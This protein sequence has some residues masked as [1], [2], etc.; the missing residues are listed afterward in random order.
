MEDSSAVIGMLVLGAWS[1]RTLREFVLAAHDAPFRFYVH[2]DRKVD[3][4]AYLADLGPAVSRMRLVPDRQ[5]VFWGGWS[6]VRATMV[7]MEAALADSDIDILT[8]VSDD[9]AFL[10]AANEVAASLRK[11]PLRIDRRPATVER[12]LR[13]SGLYFFDSR[14]TSARSSEVTHREIDPVLV[15]HVLRDLEE[16]RRTGKSDVQVHQGPQWWSMPRE[17]AEY[18]ATRLRDDRRLKLSFRYSAI[19]DESVIQTLVAERV[20]ENSELSPDACPMFFD[21]SRDPK[22][23]VFDNREQVLASEYSELLPNRLFIRK[24]SLPFARSLREEPWHL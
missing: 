14:F 1:P 16:L 24:V 21:F 15:E 13:Y 10:G 2:V 3:M 20:G 18:V 4:E 5:E 22:P 6:M 8:L 11:Q 7:L 19:P 12:Q 17:L 23:F 9:T